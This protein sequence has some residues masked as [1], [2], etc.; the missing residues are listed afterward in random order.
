MAVALAFGSAAI[1]AL[2]AVLQQR[3]AMRRTEEEIVRPGILLRLAQRPVW[4]AGVAA[5]LVGYVLQGAALGVGRLVVVEPILACSI[6]IALPFGVRLSSQRVGPRD[7]AAA[8]TVAAGLG[9]FLVLSD[10]SGGRDDAPAGH[11]LLAVGVAVGA[12]AVLLATGLRRSGRLRAALIGAAAGIFFG[13]L[14]ALT[15]GAAEVAEDHGAEVLADWHLYAA[16]AAGLGAMVL[17]QVALQAGALAPAIAGSAVLDPAVGVVLGLTLFS[18]GIHEDL[19][20]S[21]L[22]VLALLAML[23]GLAALALG[24]APPDAQP[25]PD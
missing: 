20:S 17:T 23:G 19:L 11:W 21:A 4:V 24:R 6:V 3:E 2:G 14:A 10:P 9:L 12:S 25:D 1:A 16:L 15:K 8:V 18:E 5:Y 13:L 22:A 7:V